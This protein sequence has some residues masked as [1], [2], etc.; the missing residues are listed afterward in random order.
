MGDQNK[1]V[2]RLRFPGYTD[3]WVKC[4]L[5]DVLNYEQPTK[6]I[7]DSA[8]YNDANPIPVLTAGQSFIL[9]YTDEKS[10]IKVATPLVPVIIF[11][12]FTTSSHYV[13][14]SFKVKSSAM[15]LL[16]LKKEN[17]DFYFIFNVLKNINYIP[18]SHERHWISK[19]SK[20]Q[21]MLPNIKE[22]IKI[23][24]F[25]KHLDNLIT[26]NER[27]LNKLKDLKKSYLE[28]MFPKNGSDIPELRFP[29]YADAWVKCELGDV[30]KKI[31]SYSLSR[32]VETDKHTGYKY[33]HYGDIHT[34]VAGYIDEESIL[35]NIKAD[36]FDI[37]DAGDLIVADASEDYQ[38]IAK[39]AVLVVKPTSNV[40]AGLHTIALRPTHSNSIFLYYLLQT[41]LFKQ[42]GKKAGTGM[43]VFGI[44]FSNLSKFH[45]S[46]PTEDEQH[47]IGKFLHSI[48][49][50]ITVNEHKQNKRFSPAITRIFHIIK[51]I[52]RKISDMIQNKNLAEE[53]FQEA[54]VRGLTGKYDNVKSWTAPDFLDGTKH[55]V[56]Y[57]T[58]I[59]NWRHILNQQN[60]KELEG[61]DLTDAEF[62][63]VLSKVN[64]LENSY[65]AAKLLASENGVGKIDGIIRD[66]NLAGV[67]HD[68]ITLRIFEKAK[69]NG[70]DTVYQLAREVWTE[71]DRNRFDILLL[72]NGLPLINIEQKRVDKNADEAFG[73]FRRYYQDGEYT[74]N[75]FVFSQM[76]VIMTDIDTR[77]FATPKTLEAFNPAFQFHW[78]DSKNQSINSMTDVVKTLLRIPM[79]HQMVGDYLIINEDTRDSKNQYH[80]L[81]RPYQVEAL[82]AIEYAAAG[83]DIATHVPHGG[84]VWHTTGSGK[85]ITSFKAAL[86]LSKTFDKVIFLLDRKDLDAQT[87]KNFKAY[88]QYETIEVSDSPH[89]HDLRESLSTSLKGVVVATTFKLNNVIKELQENGDDKSILKKRMAVIVDEA[90]RTT[91]GE[92]MQTIKSAL[93][94]TLFFGFTGTPLFDES[95]TVGFVNEY[96]ERMKTTEDMFGKEL[97]RYTIDEAIKDKNVLGF[98]VDYIDTGEIGSY[99]LLKEKWLAH[100]KADPLNKRS[101]DELT[102]YALQLENDRK[103]DK[104]GINIGRAELEIVLEYHDE[105]HIPQ[106]VKSIIENWE[107]HSNGSVNGKKVSHKFNGLLT[108]ALKQRVIAYYDE[109][110][111]QLAESNLKLNIMATFS[112][113]NENTDLGQKDKDNLATIF[114]DWH[115]M[116]HPLYQVDATKLENGESGFFSDITA[117]FKNG[118]HANNEKNI[119]LLIVADR[120]LTGYDSKLLNTLY[121]DRYLKLQGLI[122]AYSRTNRIYGEDKEFGTIV[123]FQYP[124]KSRYAL[125][126]ALKLYGS[127][128]TSSRV[129]VDEYA[130]VV[131]QMVPLFETLQES[132]AYPERWLDIK[133]VEPE[134]TDFIIAFRQVA[135]KLNLLQQYYEFDW[136]GTGIKALAFSEETWLKYLGAYQN[137]KPKIEDGPEDEIADLVGGTQLI[138]TQD[139]TFSEI[140]R[141]IGKLTTPSGQLDQSDANNAENER[142]ITDAIQKLRTFGDND[143]AELLEKFMA[144]VV[145]VDKLDNHLSVADNYQAFRIKTGQ[146]SL[147]AYAKTW[148]I[149]QK[150]LLKVYQHYHVGDKVINYLDELKSSN[151]YLKSD[152]YQNPE[153][154]T[155]G[156]PALRY[157]NDLENDLLN[158]LF[159]T[160]SIYGEF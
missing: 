19:F 123:N 89:T 125:E 107:K 91:M 139:I 119:D 57:Q 49:D 152:W 87:S 151:D 137:L 29:G 62:Q 135:K 95:N 72:I 144:D 142:L 134:Q 41:D 60:T 99:S 30:V 68:S 35:P 15:K 138:D 55:K 150:I 23:G 70:G 153:N 156:L 47:K 108:V 67:T 13:D 53:A 73:Q 131:K 33:I 147:E 52:L 44:T 75:F 34:N 7:V 114:Q 101:D 83:K 69:V 90:H 102:R 17:Y 45:T 126:R 59:D 155:G 5:G 140:I 25:F 71:N 4:T 58:L 117:V 112:T 146:A 124:A 109:F 88:S 50:L 32:D 116:G 61:H 28:K 148:A 106:V 2:P 10:G 3:A 96:S 36:D 133:D 92:M 103:T 54:T 81:M 111:K 42:F 51:N 11:D 141:L 85:T 154:A 38:G 65:Q 97:H 98:H 8:D 128:G 121:V 6:Y 37:L 64:T 63:Q 40:V 158:Y 31:K 157:K 74:N 115:E 26:V 93:R 127:G 130:V 1:N 78:A 12:D 120:L 84:F 118:G 110:K 27:E 56:T 132:L 18:E 80:M 16:G 122:Q 94:N 20:L 66:N 136:L 76:M 86:S 21:V 39:P 22:Q 9:G 149:D 82:R 77:Y 143:N 159:V 43:K 105:L 46:F 113:G 24:K 129:I 14:F 145:T 48:D 79:A 100:E 104:D 160:K